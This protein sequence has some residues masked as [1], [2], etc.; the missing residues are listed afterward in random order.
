MPKKI[1]TRRFLVLFFLFSAAVIG[2]GETYP[3]SSN[4]GA[5]DKTLFRFDDIDTYARSVKIRPGELS[6]DLALRLTKNVSTEIEKARVL[7]VWLTENI[8]YDAES[9]FYGRNEGRSLEELLHNGKSV[10]QG[11]A[12]LFETMGRSVGLE[13]VTIS[14]WVKGVDYS[15][16][17]FMRGAPNHA[18]NAV[19][20]EEDWYLVDCT[21]GAG[22]LSGRDYE[23]CFD[24][25]YFLTPPKQLIFSHFPKNTDWQLLEPKMTKEECLKI[26]KTWSNY[27]RCGINLL[28]DA[29]ENMHVSEE[30]SFRFSANK[31]TELLIT[32][33]DPDRISRR[34]QVFVQRSGNIYEAQ[35]RFSEKGNYELH[36]LARRE[37][38]EDPLF[39]SALALSLV[40]L[41]PSVA[42]KDF[43]ETYASFQERQ[44]TLYQ[45]MEKL[46]P[47]NQSVAFRINVPDAEEVVVVSGEEW[48]F[49]VPEDDT[50]TGSVWMQKGEVLII[51]RF[52]G[53]SVFRY[54]VEYIAEK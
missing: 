41:H 42:K 43:P 47:A 13:T 19:K 1:A 9:Y 10:C 7:Y 27:F 8:R 40:N 25:F 34:S 30:E 49:L 44:V 4:T 31:G 45:P 5:I 33:F 36:V 35:A 23:K 14:G 39:Y 2:F 6:A 21:W 15:P 50:F 12:Y 51:A 54:L 16:T 38:D 11:F 17:T 29:F 37:T 48:S 32:L 20:I 52:Y 24:D 3:I 26:P 18:W 28:S 46:L 53:E 22:Y